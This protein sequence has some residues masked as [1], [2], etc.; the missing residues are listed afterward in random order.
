MVPPA[1]ALALAAPTTST[2]AATCT[3]AALG[4]G[5]RCSITGRGQIVKLVTAV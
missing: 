5:V 3:L 1:V 4:T 2:V